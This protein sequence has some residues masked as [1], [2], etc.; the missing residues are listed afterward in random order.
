MPV[1][2]KASVKYIS[3]KDLEEIGIPAVMS[4]T[5]I[6]HLKPGERTIKKLG[7]I[8]KF[9]NFSGVNA[10]DSGGFQMYSE[11]CYI[12]SD[13]RGIIFKNP[14]SGE[15]IHI[16]PEKDM[17]I[18]LD[19]DG[20]IA[21]CLDSMPLYT[22]NKEK[23]SKAVE[24]TTLWA[25]QCKKHHEKL[26]KKISKEKTYVE[27]AKEEWKESCYNGGEG[28]GKSNEKSSMGSLAFDSTVDHEANINGKLRS[29]NGIENPYDMRSS[30]LIFKCVLCDQ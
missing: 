14:F 17:E 29:T 27:L 1:A 13:E 5:F 30:S 21:M 10:T 3:S 16:S 26:Q 18:Q 28:T 4:N 22:D 19:L 12:A 7:G 8:S 2:T 23:I 24:L 11:S 6:L 9:M 20:D 25:E 15:K